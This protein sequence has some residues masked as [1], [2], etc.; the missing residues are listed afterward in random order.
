MF[1]IPRKIWLPVLIFLLVSISLLIYFKVFHE[2]DREK[3]LKEAEYHYRSG[4]EREA[5]D[6]LDQIMRSGGFSTGEDYYYELY[7]QLGNSLYDFYYTEAQDNRENRNYKDSLHYYNELLSIL[8]SDNENIGE[9]R[10]ERREVEQLLQKQ[11]ELDEFSK[12]FTPIFNETNQLLI[13]IS[14][15][16]DE[17]YVDKI[18]MQQFKEIMKENLDI[19]GEL[20]TDISSSV[21]KVSSDLISIHNS[22]SDWVNQLHNFII[23]TT[24]LD[25]KNQLQELIN[26]HNNISRLVSDTIQNIKNYADNHLLK[27]EYQE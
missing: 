15:H 27:F 4:E 6:I 19:T 20:R 16:I 1:S 24:Q 22:I 10:N 11:K 9:L 5:F 26:V 18:T 17:L 13:S 2:T 14:N 7:Y 8:P 21:S 3:T 12:I 23:M 25:N